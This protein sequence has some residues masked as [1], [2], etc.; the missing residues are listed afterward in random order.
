VTRGPR[1]PPEDGFSLSYPSFAEIGRF[2]RA[3]SIEFQFL[4]SLGFRPGS[5]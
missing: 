3:Q 5:G 1:F 2:R 4:K